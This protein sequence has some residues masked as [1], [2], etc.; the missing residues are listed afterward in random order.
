[1]IARDG[2]SKNYND[3]LALDGGTV[4]IAHFATSGLA[5]L[6]DQMDTIKYFGKSEDFMKRDHSAKCRPPG[7]SGN[8][9]GWGCYSKIWWRD[10]MQKFLDSKESKEVQDKA[11]ILMMKPV[12]KTALSHGWNSQRDMAI[13]L[14]VANSLGETGFI[15]LAENNDWIAERTISAYAKRSD[16]TTRRKQA[17]DNF[18][19]LKH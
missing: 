17:L 18:F 14:S 7:R 9:T 8:D 13:A 16:H 4:G 12:I 15:K 2:R 19:P 1:V 6:Y 5:P 3:L 10:G 11:W